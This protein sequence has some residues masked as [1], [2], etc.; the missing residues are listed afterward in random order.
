M[1][2]LLFPFWDISGHL[3]HEFSMLGA[4]YMLEYRGASGGLNLATVLLGSSGGSVGDFR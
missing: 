4:C 1:I 3:S 2:N